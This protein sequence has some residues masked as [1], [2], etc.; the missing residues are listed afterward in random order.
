MINGR[1][2]QYALMFIPIRRRKTR[3]TAQLNKLFINTT[4]EETKTRRN[5]GIGTF[6]I[7]FAE[8]TKTFNSDVVLEKKNQP[9][10][11]IK[12]YAP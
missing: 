11:P 12:M 4:V 7:K 10:N 5:F 1:Y 2:I 8:F 3:R 9:V 6:F